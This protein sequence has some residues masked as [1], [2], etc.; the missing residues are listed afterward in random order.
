MRPSPA[1][2]RGVGL[3]VGDVRPHDRDLVPRAGAKPVTASMDARL[4]GAVGPD[5]PHH[6]AGGDGERHVVDR[7]DP[8]VADR[9]ARDG[10]GGSRR[11]DR[12]SDLG[13]HPV[14]ES[15]RA[16]AS[17]AASAS[18]LRRGAAS[19]VVF[20]GGPAASDACSQDPGSQTRQSA[21]FE[22]RVERTDEAL[23]VVDQGDDQPTPVMIAYQSPRSTHGRGPRRRC[24]RRPGSR[25]RPAPHRGDA[26]E[27]GGARSGRA[28]R[29]R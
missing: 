8:A 28:R 6:R 17:R 3:G 4:A 14:G 23:G 18:L 12:R 19:T 2:T 16:R 21:T 13:Q 22:E 9:E 10:Q 7:H 29:G 20:P 27:V 24:R 15:P 25:P 5:E 11:P 26:G 1:R